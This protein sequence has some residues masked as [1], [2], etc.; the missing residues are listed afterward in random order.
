MN[1]V[2][3]DYNVTETMRFMDMPIAAQALYFHLGINADRDGFVADPQ[4]VIRRTGCS[5]GDYKELINNGF[6]TTS[7]VSDGIFLAAS[8]RILAV[9]MGKVK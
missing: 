6:I 5:A 9:D 2:N 8:I 7:N 4:K 3:L 1:E